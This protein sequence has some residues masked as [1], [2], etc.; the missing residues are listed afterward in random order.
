MRLRARDFKHSHW[1]KRRSRSNFAS[2]LRLRDWRSMWMQDGCKVYMNSYMAS[3]GSC[4]MV[5]WTMFK[6]HLLKVGLN[7]RVGDHGTLNAHN[8]RFIL[9]YHAWGPVCIETHWNNTWLRAQSHMT[10]HYT[11]GCVTTMHNFEGVLG[12]PL[13]I[14]FWA[15]T[16]SWSW[17]VVC[18]WSGHEIQVFPSQIAYMLIS[19][20]TYIES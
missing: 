12:W 13:D 17:L 1:W 10:P 6:N 11:W 8:H 16:L 5:T 3:N 19:F 9:F 7:T 20:K 2:T 4:F 14:L 15:L 18:V